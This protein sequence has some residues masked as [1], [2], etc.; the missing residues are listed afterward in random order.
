MKHKL[1]IALILAAAA[2]ILLNAKT[3]EA[4]H[5]LSDAHITY[6]LSQYIVSEAP[7]GTS[8]SY[9]F[10]LSNPTDAAQMACVISYAQAQVHTSLPLG[11]D[12]IVNR[13]GTELVGC[14]CAIVEPHAN[15][16]FHGDFANLWNDGS[17]TVIAPVRPVILDNGAP[18][19]M[20]D[21]LGL[22]PFNR[23]GNM[24]RLVHP[25]VF[26]LPRHP[27]ENQIIRDCLCDAALSV[28]QREM[29]EGF[30]IRRCRIDD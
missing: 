16:R 28:R 8:Y 13:Y 26:N 12:G 7:G 18:T 25:S 19:F 23:V 22:V 11:R 29:W 14:E 3:G 1:I 2:L 17:E 10:Q 5:Q 4:F 21:G 6:G 9:P 27:E 15:A 30:G 24:S 20:A